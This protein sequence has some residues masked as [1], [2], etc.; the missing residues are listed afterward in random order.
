MEQHSKLDWKAASRLLYGNERNHDGPKRS[1]RTAAAILSPSAQGLES[2]RP[3][4]SKVVQRSEARL[5]GQFRHDLLPPPSLYYPQHGM[6]LIG[7]GA[8]RSAI[9]PFHDDRKPSLRIQ[10]A[11]GAFRC[12]VCGEK[13]GDVLEFHRRRYSLGFVA[14]AKDLRAWEAE[15]R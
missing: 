1:R 15:T 10:A 14:A 6:K 13:G 3:L 9:C 11:T 5:K 12:M 4:R 8:W 7:R 2:R